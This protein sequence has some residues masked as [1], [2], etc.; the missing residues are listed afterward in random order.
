MP[1]I[2]IIKITS[3]LILLFAFI[4]CSSGPQPAVPNNSNTERLLSDAGF[5]RHSADTMERME[6][7]RS[8]VQRKVFPVEEEGEMYYLYADAEFCRCLYVGDDAAFS[9]FEELLRTR[10]IERSFCID[11]R[12]RRIQE[13]PWRDF[14]ELSRLCRER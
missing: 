1:I 12:M 4:S 5:V 2:R 13:E 11:D 3:M 6:R 7:I 9:R 10:N 14:G 8:S